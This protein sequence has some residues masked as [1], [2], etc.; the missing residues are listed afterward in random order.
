MKVLPYIRGFHRSLAAVTAKL[1]WMSELKM[2]LFCISAF[3]I[4]VDQLFY[5]RTRM[6]TWTSSFEP[7]QV[8][9]FLG[10]IFFNSFNDDK[11]LAVLIL[12]WTNLDQPT[13]NIYFKK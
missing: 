12:M 6:F 4:T 9:E 11:P 13:E 8:V 10:F 5:F 7:I 1:P 2:S 3:V